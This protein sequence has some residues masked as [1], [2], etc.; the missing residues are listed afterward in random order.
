VQIFSPTFEP[1][2]VIGSFGG[3]EGQFSRPQGLAFDRAANELYVADSNNHRVVVYD[4]D[5]RRLRQ[6]GTPGT[7]VGELAYPRGIVFCGD[8]T[9]LLVEF[10]NHR[11]QRFVAAPGER[12][13]TS[14]GVWGGM[15]TGPRPQ[16]IGEPID[17]VERHREIEVE[18]GRLQ[19][20]WDMA[21]VGGHVMVLDSSN[22]RVMLAKIP[23]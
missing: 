9:I 23:S 19:Y 11:V 12:F 21:G 13:G 17:V 3:G 10:G 22:N 7:A 15:S 2:G 8:G 6:F 18:P 16:P 1:I 4:P 5:G 20:P 14:L